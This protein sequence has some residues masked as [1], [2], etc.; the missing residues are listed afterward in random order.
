MSLLPGSGR[1]FEV[2]GKIRVGGL[3]P[4][5]WRLASRVG[6]ARPACSPPA[7]SCS[8]ICLHPAAAVAC[9]SISWCS[10]RFG[11]KA[12]WRKEDLDG[13]EEDFS[14]LAYTVVDVIKYLMGQV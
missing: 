9:C 2:G 1:D 14:Q 3:A 11:E 10:P 6:C 5:A 7:R 12:I 4:A 13:C 8:P